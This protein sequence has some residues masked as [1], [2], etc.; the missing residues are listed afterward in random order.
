MYDMWLPELVVV[1]EKV[2]YAELRCSPLTESR[3]SLCP[4]AAGLI[5][6]FLPPAGPALGGASPGLCPALLADDDHGKPGLMGGE[7]SDP[8]DFGSGV[9]SLRSSP[10]ARG[11]RM[12]LPPFVTVGVE[13]GGECAPG[14]VEAMTSSPF[15]EAIEPCVDM[16]RSNSPEKVGL[17]SV[18]P[19][20]R[21]APPKREEVSLVEDRSE[22]GTEARFAPRGGGSID[23]VP[24][25]FVTEDWGLREPGP[26]MSA[27][28]A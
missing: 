3:V 28:E 12:G 1:C 15:G 7:R 21:G 8:G 25:A 14:E 13:R 20:S 9:G 6:L 10:G 5:G 24:V 23:S 27:I 22:T 26:T 18:T 2:E 4:F 17:A 19:L 16:R 11:G